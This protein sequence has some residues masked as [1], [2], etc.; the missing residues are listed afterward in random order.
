MLRM[1]VFFYTRGDRVEPPTYATDNLR[2]TSQPKL[3]DFQ[4][5][6]AQLN[7][8]SNIQYAAYG[9][10]LSWEDLGLGEIEDSGTEKACIDCTLQDRMELQSLTD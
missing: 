1:I 4:K 6:K 7:L 10:K 2:I 3:I 5:H 8:E 9:S